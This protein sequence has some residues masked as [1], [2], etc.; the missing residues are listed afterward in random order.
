VEIALR[1]GE[2]YDHVIL[3]GTEPNLPLAREYYTQVVETYGR[4]SGQSTWLPM[5]RAHM[6]LGNLHARQRKYAKS[7][8][9]YE[10]IYACDPE[11]L[12]PLPYREL[13]GQETAET[14]K[15]M[16]QKEAASLKDVVRRHL[17]GNCVRPD[18]AR[19][20]AE[21]DAIVR[22]Y[23]E[24]QVIVTGAAQLRETLVNHMTELE[25]VL[26]ESLR[27]VEAPQQD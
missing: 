8:D 22:K 12:A 21:L 26:E 13:S 5:L 10:A 2:L 7:N 11:S 24:D 27:E 17:V 14:A 20:F 23:A 1:L 9:H 6:H 15:E 16:L 19:S 25:K 18:L 4:A 3:P